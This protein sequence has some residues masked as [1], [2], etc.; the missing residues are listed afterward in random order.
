[1]N[2]FYLTHAKASKRAER[3]EKKNY[4]NETQQ[5]FN[6]NLLPVAHD[7][8]NWQIYY[9]GSKDLS[10]WEYIVLFIEA[11]KLTLFGACCGSSLDAK[12][13]Y[14][15]LHSGKKIR[16]IYVEV[17]NEEQSFQISTSDDPVASVSTENNDP[18]YNA[19][20]NN[21]NP[22][23]IFLKAGREDLIEKLALSPYAPKEMLDD[24][25]EETLEKKDLKG[26]QLFIAA[27]AKFEKL[28]SFFFI[29]IYNTN[30]EI[31]RWIIEQLGEQVAKIIDKDGTTLLHS[32]V[33]NHRDVKNRN[34]WLK[35]L[36][37][38]VKLGISPQQKGGIFSNTP[39]DIACR[40]N[41]SDVYKIFTKFMEDPLN[42]PL[43]NAIF[44]EDLEQIKK[45]LN[46][47]LICWE[48]S[49]NQTA[50][51]VLVEENK[52]NLLPL[53]APYCEGTENHKPFTYNP[54]LT[55]LKNH[56]FEMAKALWNIGI[57]P[58]NEESKELKEL[59]EDDPEVRIHFTSISDHQPEI[60]QLFH[61]CK[62]NDLSVVQNIL[63]ASPWLVN[64]K[65]KER[66][67]LGVAVISNSYDV[68]NF[69][70][71]QEGS[72]YGIL[73]DEYW[74]NITAESVPLYSAFTSQSAYVLNLFLDALPELP[75]FNE[76]LKEDE[77]PANAL[78]MYHLFMR[79]LDTLI[80]EKNLDSLSSLASHPKTKDFILSQGLV[81]AVI[82]NWDN[83]LI[84]KMIKDGFNLNSI[85][86]I[87]EKRILLTPL[88]AAIN[89]N[90]IE[91]T[92][93]F[94]DYGSEFKHFESFSHSLPEP[95]Y[96]A[97]I[98]EKSDMEMLLLLLD[99]YQKR[100]MLVSWDLLAHSVENFSGDERLIFR[101]LE[102]KTGLNPN[103]NQEIAEKLSDVIFDWKLNIAKT[104]YSL[105]S[106]GVTYNKSLDEWNRMIKEVREF[107]EALNQKLI[108]AISNEGC[109][110]NL[111][112]K[113]F[114]QESETSKLINQI[115][116]HILC[117]M[118]S[119]LNSDPQVISKIKKLLLLLET[120]TELRDRA[121]LALQT[122]S[123]LE[124][125]GSAIKYAEKIASGA[126]IPPASFFKLHGSMTQKQKELLLSSSDENELSARLGQSK[127]F[128]FFKAQD[129]LSL[130][131]YFLKSP[132]G[133]ISEALEG[134]L[135]YFS[136]FRTREGLI[137][138]NRVLRYQKDSPEL[139]L[140]ALKALER[141]GIKRWSKTIENIQIQEIISII[142]ICHDVQ[143]KE[144]AFRTLWAL[145]GDENDLELKTL[146]ARELE[147]VD[148]DQMDSKNYALTLID[149]LGNYACSDAK[150]CVEV[151]QL[152]RRLLQSSD[153]D[154]VFQTAL[155]ISKTND[156]AGLLESLKVIEGPVWQ[157]YAK[158]DGKDSEHVSGSFLM[159]RQR[160]AA[161]HD[162]KHSVRIRIL[163]RLAMLEANTPEY[164]AQVEERL[165]A[166]KANSKNNNELQQFV[167]HFQKM[168]RV[169]TRYIGMPLY[170][171]SGSAIGR[172]LSSRKG[173]TLFFEAIRDLIRKG[174][175]STDLTLETSEVEG[176]TWGRIG[177]IFGSHKSE[178]FFDHEGT[179]FYGSNSA[180]LVIDADYYNSEF[181]CGEARLESETSFNNVWYRGVPKKQLQAIFLEKQNQHDV[182]LLAGDEPLVMI[183]DAL[184]SPIFKDQE[185]KELIQLRR[186]L[187]AKDCMMIK[188]K[189]VYLSLAER[190]HYYDS[191]QK[192]PLPLEEVEKVGFKF[193]SENELL[194]ESLRRAIG[195][196]LIEEKL[197]K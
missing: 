22:W 85:C 24:C 12:E 143:V 10:G 3:Y 78:R 165:K 57:G 131:D 115:Y 171:P 137:L 33:C 66:V 150:I 46:Y 101:F 87:G 92:K 29:K 108:K 191:T 47:N 1:M 163:D 34:Q 121:L 157:R 177:H 102:A 53:F 180:F 64:V 172:G 38:L 142:I 79:V 86:K 67:A 90:N 192:P 73:E 40:M 60:Q 119:Q 147:K 58:G 179:Y 176:Q 153:T 155:T 125:I 94:I 154:I 39:I 6:N 14:A 77:L 189:K 61:A 19:V 175:G 184:T 146:L 162:N 166:F 105:L 7:G 75:S 70:L 72:I 132:V 117:G 88:T 107:A 104:G 45:H 186:H 144:Q 133:D 167:D 56:H 116:Y 106:Y 164:I 62:T 23:L 170:F 49:I 138:C 30:Y 112:L 81:L 113:Y 74:G 134:W 145:S 183:K 197:S 15:V 13:I 8:R 195:R 31:Y 52:L 41:L 148:F 93:L 127:T 159:F 5:R 188:G 25:L 185:V 194:E 130:C 28:N 68:V 173:E 118:N 91:L 32:M 35:D 95:M 98:S 100:K 129:Y 190:I 123:S 149:L 21:S 122:G 27:G 151:A 136:V 65:S 126:K 69:L 20:I 181:M 82:A 141:I 26:A 114:D 193:P 156:R 2:P 120:Q 168:P 160:P 71:E 9:S 178:L 37:E 109:M 54:L 42:S 128:E 140:K 80:K 196:Q 51:D 135:N 174:C 84:E 89:L 63:K 17:D 182:E 50:L 11:I 152:L 48:N 139:L 18:L 169:N 124:D 96:A 76:L 111:F 103:E 59:L 16:T 99:V 4:T 43:H 158:D 97:C 44:K 110:G 83:N 161:L 36:E 55:A 187:K